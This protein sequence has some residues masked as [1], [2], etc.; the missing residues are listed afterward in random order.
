MTLQVRFTSEATSD[1]EHAV[2][3]Y[4]QRHTGLGL[5]FLAAVDQAVD[6]A[7]QWP[8]MGAPVEG[9]AEDVEA[10]RAPT[11]RFPYYVA[12]IVVDEVLVV[13]AIAHE[14]RRPVYWSKRATT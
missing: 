4:E 11:A 10:R 12:Y 9:V 14:R 7:A 2:R 1:L 6:S 8:R 3:W 5:A 13:L